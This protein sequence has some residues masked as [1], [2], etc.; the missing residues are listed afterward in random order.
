MVQTE[1]NREVEDSLL[2]E[3]IE[4]GYE[5]DL[6]IVEE[7]E[8]TNP[9][10]EALLVRYNRMGSYY[11]L[12]RSLEHPTL[13]TLALVGGSTAESRKTRLQR[14]ADLQVPERFSTLEEAVG[15]AKLTTEADREL[16]ALAITV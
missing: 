15:L 8:E 6:D 16:E 14:Y 12:C 9:A 10:L 1:R 4:L 13:Y 11:V 5:R 2:R 7:L 3:L